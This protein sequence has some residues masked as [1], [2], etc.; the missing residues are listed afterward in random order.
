LNLAFVVQAD[1]AG[2][3]ARHRGIDHD[4]ANDAFSLDVGAGHKNDAVLVADVV[5]RPPHALAVY[6]RFAGGLSFRPGD[7]GQHEL[8][9]LR[10]LSECFS[11][12]GSAGHHR[13]CTDKRTTINPIGKGRVR[14]W[15]PDQAAVVRVG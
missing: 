11:C 7:A 1:G 3:G 4:L 13:G 12:Q 15:N 8:C 2:G 14:G 5:E 10:R 6:H 9:F